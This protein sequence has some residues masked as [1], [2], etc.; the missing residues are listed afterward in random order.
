MTCMAC[1]GPFHPATGHQ[2]SKTATL[3]GPCAGR[4]F[5]W[6]IRHTRR[7]WSGADFYAAAAT[8]IRP[9]EDTKE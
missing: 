7:R 2:F 6:V 3:C 9:R 4:F 1:K 5:A 8:S